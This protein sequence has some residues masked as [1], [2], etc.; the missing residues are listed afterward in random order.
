MNVS[1]DC[2]DWLKEQSVNF[3]KPIAK[4]F[5]SADVVE[6]LTPDEDESEDSTRWELVSDMPKPEWYSR[7][8]APGY[9]DCT[10]WQGPYDTEEEALEGLYEVFGE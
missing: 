3:M 8:S 1:K 4:Y 9:M 2:K 10:E 5:D 6:L 7:L